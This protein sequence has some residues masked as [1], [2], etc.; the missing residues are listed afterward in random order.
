MDWAAVPT[1]GAAQSFFIPPETRGN[2]LCC[3]CGTSIPPN[4]TSMC[5]ACIRSQVDITEGIQ[6]QVSILWCKECERYLQP[7]KHWVRAALES[8]ELLTFCLKRIKGLSKVQ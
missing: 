6:K 8:K 4:R 5:I 1:A 2:V 3:L 7:P